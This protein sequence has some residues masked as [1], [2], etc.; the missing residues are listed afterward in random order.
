MSQAP[1]EL[2]HMQQLLPE[3]LTLCEATE[4][5]LLTHVRLCRGTGRTG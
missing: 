5:C 4:A 2:L 1:A 3:H